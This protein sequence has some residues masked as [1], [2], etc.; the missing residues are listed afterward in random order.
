M[1]G[2]RFG[3]ALLE[4]MLAVPDFRQTDR[5]QFYL[6]RAKFIDLSASK[7]GFDVLKRLPHR[8][9]SIEKLIEL[10]GERDLLRSIHGISR[11]PPLS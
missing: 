10:L 4:S 7:L 9:R 3:R 1:I 5:F 8:S 11:Q 2:S 6:D